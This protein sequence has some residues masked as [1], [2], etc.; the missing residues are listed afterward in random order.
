MLILLWLSVCSMVQNLGGRDAGDGVDCPAASLEEAPRLGWEA[1]PQKA[2]GEVCVFGQVTCQTGGATY[3][4]TRRWGEAASTQIVEYAREDGT[5]VAVFDPSQADFECASDS[6]SGWFGEVLYGC[7]PVGEEL[8]PDCA[9]VGLCAEGAVEVDPPQGVP[10]CADGG[11]VSAEESALAALPN[12][13][14]VQRTGQPFDLDADGQDDVLVGYGGGAFEVLSADG[15]GWVQVGRVDL[16]VRV[17][18][19]LAGEVDDDGTP[20]LVGL[21]VGADS[22]VVVVVTGPADGQGL[23][24]VDSFDSALPASFGA[25]GLLPGT[26]PLAAMVASAPG[27]S[28]WALLDLGDV[29]GEPWTAEDASFVWIGPGGDQ[30]GDGL[31]DLVGDN[32]SEVVAWPDPRR[33][34]AARIT[35]VELTADLMV[36]VG[37]LDGDGAGDLLVQANGSWAVRPGPLR[38]LGADVLLQP[39]VEGDAVVA[40]DVDGDGANDVLIASRALVGAACGLRP[41]QASPDRATVSWWSSSTRVVRWVGV[42]DAAVSAVGI[43]G[44]DGATAIGVVD[45]AGSGVYAVCTR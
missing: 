4:R 22:L 17:E 32:G 24:S 38:A 3:V 9:D 2:G 1:E 5:L 29:A 43:G 19:W 42:S 45:E 21:V 37:D 10:A 44:I 23:L 16:D 27:R 26:G 14:V 28:K 40:E 41:D 39:V 34:P 35:T 18:A 8:S 31:D 36:P 13:A 6:G 11:D 12:G 25:A 20:G 7:E 15:D 30:D 33:G